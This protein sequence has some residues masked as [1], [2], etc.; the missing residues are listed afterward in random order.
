MNTVSV[1]I[2]GTEARLSDCIA[3]CDG[4]NIQNPSAT[5]CEGVTL[6]SSVVTDNCALVGG[7]LEPT[8]QIGA[9][10]GRVLRAVV[11]PGG[12]TTIVTGGYSTVASTV[13]GPANTNTVTTTTVSISVQ[14]AFVTTGGTGAGTGP[15][16]V[17]TEY[18][19]ST[20]YGV[21]TAYSTVVSNGIT[22]IQTYGV[23]T[24]ISISLVPATAS[25]VTTTLL[26]YS[27]GVTTVLSNGVTTVLVPSTVLGPTV[28]TNGGTIT[29]A[30]PTV[31]ATG[32]GG[33]NGGTVTV[34]LGGGTT[35]EKSTT[36][37]TVFS[38]VLPSSTSHSS[39]SS[40]TCRTTSTNYLRGSLPGKRSFFDFDR[41]L[42]GDE[43]L[44]R[45]GAVPA[46]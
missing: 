8:N 10:S 20:V 33:T 4:Y 14:T 13:V 35:T 12:D 17:V 37:T 44:P 29:V 9:Y 2:F 27:Y 19:P 6:D 28:T 16:G 7:T 30:G 5:Q 21:S 32:P 31:T 39:T 34:S 18:V 3:A 25:T 43:L 24:A 38:Y 41:K 36:T 1:P 42:A 11:G 40:N 46:L 45:P 23:S 22:I 26:T 15:G